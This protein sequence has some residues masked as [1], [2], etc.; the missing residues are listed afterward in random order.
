MT[1]ATYEKSGRVATITLSRPESRNAI[2]TQENYD[3]LANAL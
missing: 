1:F 3:D 2:A